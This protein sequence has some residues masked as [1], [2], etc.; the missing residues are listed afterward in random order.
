[1]KL[2]LEVEGPY[3]NLDCLGRIPESK[4]GRLPEAEIRR[5]VRERQDGK[6]NPSPICGEVLHTAHQPAN[7]IYPE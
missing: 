6:S 7:K 5:K 2:N 3:D 1:M 4:L